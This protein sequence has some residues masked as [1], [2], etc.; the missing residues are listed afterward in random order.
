MVP[1]LSCH[2]PNSLIARRFASRWSRNI[3]WTAGL[4]PMAIPWFSSYGFP[5]SQTSLSRLHTVLCEAGAGTLWP[6]ILLLRGIHSGLSSWEAEGRIRGSLLLPASGLYCDHTHPTS[7]VREQWFFLAAVLNCWQVPPRT[8]EPASRHPH[9]D[10]ST[11]ERSSLLRTQSQSC[12]ALLSASTFDNSI[13]IPLSLRHY[14]S[15]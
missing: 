4:V 3:V 8:W 10:T 13:P 9:W 11:S 5:S 1:I 15:S 14:V 2:I 7:L 6:P 12:G